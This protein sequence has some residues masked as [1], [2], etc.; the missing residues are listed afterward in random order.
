MAFL[1][2]FIL[3]LLLSGCEQI[4]YS[5]YNAEKGNMINM[6]GI[7]YRSMPVTVW[8]PVSN[9]KTM[10]GTLRNFENNGQTYNL[11]TYVADENKIFL[12]QKE[13]GSR[14]IEIFYYRDDIVLPTYDISGI[15][16]IGFG[17]W[18]DT[19]YTNIIKEP[20]TIEKLFNIKGDTNINDSPGYLP[21]FWLELM[22]SKYSGIGIGLIVYAKENTYWIEVKNDFNYNAAEIPQSILEEIAGKK[23]PTASEYIA[24]QQ[25][26]GE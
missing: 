19:E 15:D 4:H 5:G 21:V 26:T 22:N 6:N 16:S 7:S 3:V 13:E 23:L 20:K 2:S 18:N 10:V 9:Q 24:S 14:T 11:F 8:R 25:K 12:M 17:N 1:I